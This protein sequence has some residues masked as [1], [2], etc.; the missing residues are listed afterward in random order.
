MILYASPKS[1][2]MPVEGSVVPV[3]VFAD[4]ER[5]AKVVIWLS[6]ALRQKLREVV[7]QFDYD[8]IS[9]AHDETCAECREFNHSEADQ[10]DS[11]FPIPSFW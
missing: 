1:V 11:A 5:N 10:R 7:R 3:L 8:E 2:E 9:A 6:V 4:E